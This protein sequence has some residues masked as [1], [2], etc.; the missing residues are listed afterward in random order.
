MHNCTSV[1]RIASNKEESLVDKFYRPLHL[2]GNIYKEGSKIHF[3]TKNLEY[4]IKLSYRAKEEM[5]V[6]RAMSNTKTHGSFNLSQYHQS[7]VFDVSLLKELELKLQC[8]SVSINNLIETLS[9]ILQ[10]ISSITLKT[11]NLYEDTVSKISNAVDDKIKNMF[12]MIVKIEEIT[13]AMKTVKKLSL[14]IKEIKTLVS[15]FESLCD[16]C[17]NTD[18]VLVPS[19]K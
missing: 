16:N 8:L 7:C 10:D 3:V 19:I 4:K 9:S 15:M 2:D 14:E 5:K 13:Q 18:F 1:R 11:L 6:P 17:T 12:I